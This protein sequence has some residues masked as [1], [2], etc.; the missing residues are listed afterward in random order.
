MSYLLLDPDQE[1]IAKFVANTAQKKR[2]M[3]ADKPEYYPNLKCIFIPVGG[4]AF[5]RST[6]G[7]SV[8]F[9]MTA[10][11]ALSLFSA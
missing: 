7:H 1:A 11:M 4:Q 8:L 6:Q 5:G 9:A 3:A 2:I 10:S